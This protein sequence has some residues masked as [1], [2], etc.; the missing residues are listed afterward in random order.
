MANL[1][2]EAPW[3]TYEKMV[4]ALFEKDPDVTVNDLIESDRPDFSYLLMITVKKHDKYLAL[5]RV[6]KKTK[7]FGN[8]KVGVMLFDTEND[9]SESDRIELYKTIFDGNSS[10]RSVEEVVDFAGTHL[11]Y[12]CFEPEVIQFHDDDISDIDGKWN[13]LAQDIAKEVFED[14]FGVYYCT[15]A[16]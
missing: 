16:K 8:I 12:V 1:K 7:V 2:I 10:V 11:G 14:A 6:I 5:D 15:A 9:N 13:G 4:K 3:Y